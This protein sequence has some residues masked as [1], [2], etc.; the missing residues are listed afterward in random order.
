MFLEVFVNDSYI[1][2]GILLRLRN[3]PTAT[4]SPHLCS[5]MIRSVLSLLLPLDSSPSPFR[6]FRDKLG[7]KKSMMYGPEQ[8]Y[9]WRRQDAR[10]E[11]AGDLAARRSL[12][13]TDIT[14]GGVASRHRA[15]SLRG[16]TTYF[17]IWLG[18]ARHAY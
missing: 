14:T 9:S 8:H 7:L 18:R 13:S 2:S 16:S 3:H 1:I 15:D 10:W 4:S 11:G 17:R 12:A 5:P 6:P